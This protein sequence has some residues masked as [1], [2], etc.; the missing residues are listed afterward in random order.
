M[1]SSVTPS[2]LRSPLV[3]GT[4]FT[5]TISA[6][7]TPLTEYSSGLFAIVSS[8]IPCEFRV[9]LVLATPPT[10]MISVGESLPSA[11]PP[12]HKIPPFAAAYALVIEPS[13]LD[14]AS[15]SAPVPDPNTYG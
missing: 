13:S 7:L 4:P 3:L 5:A 2:A 11:A 6:T 9:A 12:P 14:V 10:V 15:P 8:V 1:V